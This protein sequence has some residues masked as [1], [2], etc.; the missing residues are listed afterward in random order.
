M[1]NAIVCVAAAGD[2]GSHARTLSVTLGFRPARY[3]KAGCLETEHIGSARR[4]RINAHALEHVRAV[5]ARRLDSEEDLALAGNGS[6]A[7]HSFEHVRTARA[8]GHDC[9][10]RFNWTAHTRPPFDFCDLVDRAPRFV[11]R[12]KL[13]GRLRHLRR[14]LRG[15]ARTLRAPATLSNKSRPSL[16]FRRR[17]R[18]C[19]QPH[20]SA[21]WVSP[22]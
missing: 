18:S 19:R 8:R 16:A 21:Y 1:Y 9:T 11:N 20:F 7:Q 6:R 22:S 10:H 4:R 3:D 2:Q 15:N 17:V 13:V 12:D 14:A 5:D